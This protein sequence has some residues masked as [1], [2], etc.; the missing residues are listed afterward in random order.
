MLR[1]RFHTSRSSD[2]TWRKHFAADAHVIGRTTM[3]DDGAGLSSFTIVGVMPPEFDYPGGAAVWLPLARTLG[4]LSVGAGYDMVE[5][6]D[7][8]ILY[9]LGRLKPSTHV[10]EAHADMA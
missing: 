4:R 10:S 8:G 1:V 3:M 6:R 7:L 5:A 9:V 2:A